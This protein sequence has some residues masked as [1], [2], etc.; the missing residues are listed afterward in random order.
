LSPALTATE[1]GSPESLKFAPG[2]EVYTDFKNEFIGGLRNLKR[3]DPAAT[4][5]A[6]FKMVDAE[7]PPLRFNLGSHNL[8]STKAAYAE[9][10]KIWEAWDA[11]SSSAQG[12]PM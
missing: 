10:I 9:R 4:P 12:E 11:V 3:G 5:Q 6:L 1:F 7:N 8:P 2:L